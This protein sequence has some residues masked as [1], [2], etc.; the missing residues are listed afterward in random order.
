[1][2][3]RKTHDKFIEEL[4]IINPMIKV[5]E[6]YTNTRTKLKCLCLKCGNEWLAK[7]DNLLSKHGCPICNS[8][9]KSHDQFKREL[10]LKHPEIEL[11]S[12]YRNNKTKVKI[13]HLDCGHIEYKLPTDLVCQHRGCYLCYERAKISDAEFKKRVKKM[14][15]HIEVVG[16]YINAKTNVLCRC[17]RDGYEWLASPYYLTHNSEVCPKC[18]QIVKLTRDEVNIRLRDRWVVLLDEC[19]GN[20]KKYNFHCLKCGRNFISELNS[21]LSNNAGCPICNRSAGEQKIEDFLIANNI[22]YISQYKFSDLFG[23]KGRQLSYDFYIPSRNLL[24]EYQGK[25]H[26]AAIDYFGGGENFEIQQEHDSRKREYAKMHSFD[27]LEIKYV[28][29]KRV[30]QILSQKL[31]ICNNEKSA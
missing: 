27:L 29:F 23:V 12:E 25:Q 28:D 31:N 20:H 10:F 24:V 2:A 9:H 11:L 13:R 1:M 18:S 26:Y 30:S 4:K 16:D 8:K 21:V 15:P 5:L 7:P 3:K 19:D 22:D 17:L 14:N 6:Q